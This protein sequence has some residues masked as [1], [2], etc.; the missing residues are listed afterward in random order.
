MVRSETY[1]TRKY[2]AKIDDTSIAQRFR[3]QKPDMVE[4]VSAR[5]A[6]LVLIEEKAK[7]VCEAAGVSVIQIPFYLNFARQ[8][9]RIAKQFS[10]ATQTNE[11]YYRYE[12]WLNQGLDATILASIAEMCGVTIADYPKP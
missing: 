12:Y 6:E 11:C 9:Y 10:Q 4:Q 2:E 7:A 8:C 3:D 5:F 1:R